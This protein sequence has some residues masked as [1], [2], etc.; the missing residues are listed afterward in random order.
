MKV[1]A[2]SLL[3]T[4]TRGTELTQATWDAETPG[5]SVFVKFVAPW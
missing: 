2:L 1:L 5:K 3:A 4:A